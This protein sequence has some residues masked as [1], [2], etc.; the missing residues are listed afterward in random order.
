M[1][2]TLPADDPAPI[3]RAAALEAERARYTFSLDIY[4][5][6]AMVAHRPE[7][8]ATPPEWSSILDSALE[9]VVRNELHTE[10][11]SLAGLGARAA[12]ARAVL[13][14]LV[15]GDLR[16]AA[17]D[18][19]SLLLGGV[20][21]GPA[22]S[23]DDYTALFRTVPKP[24]AL[25]AVDDDSAF[26]R[27]WLAGS[28]P[29]SIERVTALDPAF[30]V[31]DAHLATVDDADTLA[32]ALE[33]GRLYQVD[34][35]MLDGL[36]PN[37]LHAA[38]IGV[39]PAR[40]ML[41]RPRGSALPRLFAIQLR[42]ETGPDT[43]IF[44]PA[45][46]F[47]W[48]IA[49]THLAAADTLTG[50]IWFHHARTHLV[51]EP[52]LVAAHRTLAPQHPLMVLL[53]QHGQGTLY[54]NE[55]GSHTVFAPHGLLDWFTGTSRDG[56]R[57]LARRSVATFDFRAST[58][59][60]RLAA[61]GVDDKGLG[62][63]FRDDGLLVWTALRDWIDAYLRL[64]YPSD[65]AVAGDFELASWVL[66]AGS[67]DGGG[68]RGLGGPPRT[69]ASLV[70]LVTQLVFAGSALHAAMNFPVAEELTVIPASPFGT[71][72]PPPSRTDG[73]TEADWLRALPPLDAAWRQFDTA[74]LLGLS[75]V[76]RLGD[77]PAGAF[78]DPRVAAPLAAFR[79]ALAHVESTIEARNRSREPYI[80]ML[81]SRIP[82][83]INI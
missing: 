56:L 34:Y 82:P 19:T 71:W 53:A 59:P 32:A 39:T 70:D 75:R 10:H 38:P 40:A 83:S 20:A 49:R 16:T 33:Q 43:P 62:F 17:N 2:P 47:G 51:A 55:I 66:A 12:E 27:R 58:F 63:P 31:R 41:V 45:D 18:A 81:P 65:A 25:R 7:D 69:V 72:A 46:G 79:A 67:A 42:T 61:R 36:P 14:D 5:G 35:R 1:H 24:R 23:I 80:H 60:A 57:E 22:A 26:C 54:I 78:A 4:P 68:I 76:G 50:A 28:N 13:R 52:M 6:L 64:Y 74:L 77:Y 8:D 30:P 9:Q 44:T 73:H 29:E 15:R 21:R 3:A 48:R 11:P 37:T